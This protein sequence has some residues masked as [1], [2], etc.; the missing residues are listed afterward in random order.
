VL[1]GKNKAGDSILSDVTLMYAHRWHTWPRSFT[2]TDELV[3]ALAAR[4]LA[5]PV[6][7]R[8]G[9]VIVLRRDE[10]KL[11]PLESKILNLVRSSGSL[12]SLEGSSPDVTP[13]RFW[14]NGDPQPTDG[15]LDPLVSAAQDV[16]KAETEIVQALPA[17]IRNMEGAPDALPDGR[18]DLAALRHANVEV[19]SQFVRGQELASFWGDVILSRTGGYL[20]LDLS[21]TSPSICRAL[22]TAASRVSGVVRVATTATQADER[23]TPVTDEQATEACTQHPG[24]IRLIMDAHP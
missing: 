21:K 19:P 7:L 1:L 9:D 10:K 22:L 18:V 17:F 14:K 4:I 2:F 13:F 6:E 15:C 16:S 3:P 20:T 24:F 11:G 8:T 5:A 23:E 12:C